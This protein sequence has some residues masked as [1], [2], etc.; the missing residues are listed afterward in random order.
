M[1]ITKPPRI[2]ALGQILFGIL[3]L[4]VDGGGHDPAFIGKSGGAYAGEQRAG[5]QT[6]G[7][8]GGCK[9]FLQR[10]MAEAVDQTH[11][12]HQTQGDQLDHG[13]GG[14]QFARQFGRKR[15][16][17]IDGAQIEQRQ[18]HALGADDAATFRGRNKQ[19]EIGIGGGNKFKGVAGGQ[20]GQR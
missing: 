2:S 14:L 19:R 18:S 17:S 11:D 20:P 4:R 3:D 6:L 13:S 7:G 15:V 5:R 9:V 12:G 16:D 10:A 1:T 8:N